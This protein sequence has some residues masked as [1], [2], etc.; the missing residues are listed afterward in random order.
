MPLIQGK[1]QPRQHGEHHNQRRRAGGD[2][3]PEQEKKRYADEERPAE[4]H[5]LPFCQS[6][7]HFGFYF[8]QVLGYGYKCQS[9]STSFHFGERERSL[10]TS[11]PHT[12]QPG[13]CCLANSSTRGKSPIRV[14]ILSR[15]MSGF[16]L[17]CST[18]AMIT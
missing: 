13:A 1:K 15:T 3:A 17:C 7:Q 5:K 4:T 6:E 2:A 8:C 12:S 10:S 14:M 11:L 9:L 16:L 18:G